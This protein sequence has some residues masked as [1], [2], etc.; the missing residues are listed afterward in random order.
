VAQTCNP[1]ILEARS[2][3][4]LQVVGRPCLSSEFNSSQC[5]LAR[6]CLKTTTKQ[7]EAVRLS[8]WRRLL[9]SLRSRER[10]TPG[11]TCWKERNNSASCPLTATGTQGKPRHVHT[12]THTHTHK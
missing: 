5:Y 1:S 3:V 7:P 10:A 2:G 4:S 8:R 11:S 12:H 9:P 6:S